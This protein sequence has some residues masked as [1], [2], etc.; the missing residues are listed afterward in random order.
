MNI[1]TINQKYPLVRITVPVSLI[2]SD[3]G[4]L[5]E[6]HFTE[7]PLRFDPYLSH[8]AA[9]HQQSANITLAAMNHNR[10]RQRNLLRTHP[11]RQS[12]RSKRNRLHLQ[13]FRP[14]PDTNPS[15]TLRE[16]THLR[17]T[18]RTNPNHQKRTLPNHHHEQ[19]RR[20]LPKT[21]PSPHN[22]QQF[23]G[24]KK[25]ARFYCTKP[26]E[27]PSSLPLRLLPI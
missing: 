22:P 21:I 2:K 1:T 25:L 20:N 8:D 9:L 4:L 26:K 23:H 10:H 18:W 3:K 24:H 27:N 12:I 15:T 17:P 16:S 19:S 7:N 5:K 14:R 11:R 6:Y 13:Q